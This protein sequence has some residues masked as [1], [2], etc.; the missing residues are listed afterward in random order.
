MVVYERGDGKLVSEVPVFPKMRGCDEA[1]LIGVHGRVVVENNFGHIVNFPHSQYV[2]N[3]PGI[4]LI[5][6]DKKDS[7]KVI[8]NNDHACTSQSLVCPS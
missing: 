8:R 4:A 3:E 7:S 6:V 2:A 1:S 5:Q